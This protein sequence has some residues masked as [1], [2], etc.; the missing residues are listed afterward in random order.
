MALEPAKIIAFGRKFVE[1][2]KND[3]QFP[4]NFDLS[5]DS[6]TLVQKFLTSL[7]QDKQN[8]DPSYVSKAILAMAV[9][10]GDYLG[11]TPPIESFE[12]ITNADGSI[13]D[14]VLISPIHGGSIHKTNLISLVMK[15][16][17]SPEEDNLV[18]KIPL[19]KSVISGL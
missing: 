12:I 2:L 15:A 3:P 17:S 19:L 18:Q 6:L 13:K 1:V 5:P 9:Y 14:L 8:L 7:Q 16:M 4:V 11:N 10:I